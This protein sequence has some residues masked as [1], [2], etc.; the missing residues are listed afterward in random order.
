VDNKLILYL[1]V[2]EVRIRSGMGGGA[3]VSWA[4]YPWNGNGVL[5]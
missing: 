2:Y 4:G 3:V 1:R 5:V